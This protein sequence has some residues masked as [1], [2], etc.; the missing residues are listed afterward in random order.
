MTND[1]EYRT[2]FRGTAESNVQANAENTKTRSDLIP[3]TRLQ[4]AH[5]EQML[6]KNNDAITYSCCQDHTKNFTKLSSQQIK[7]QKKKHTH[8][9]AQKN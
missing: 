2:L 1:H 6:D 7:Q 9:K 5:C 3:T 4:I 8:K